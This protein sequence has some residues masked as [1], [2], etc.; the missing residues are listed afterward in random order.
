MLESPHCLRDSTEMI[1]DPF[2]DVLKFANA[3]SVASGGFT[4]GGPWAIRFPA[5]DK[6][7]FFGLVKGN[8]G[9]RAV[10]GLYVREC[11]QQRLQADDR[12]RSE[13][14]P[15]KLSLRRAGATGS[16]VCL[17]RTHRPGNG[18]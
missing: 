9:P 13:T 4:A 15:Y 2:S 11:V 6:I 8:V 14:L 7:K 17:E 10:A 16:N 5:P 1:A 12:R 18:W 3:Q